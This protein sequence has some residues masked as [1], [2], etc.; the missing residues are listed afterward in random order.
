MLAC[1]PI[2]DGSN[3]PQPSLGGSDAPQPF[4]KEREDFL[5]AFSDEYKDDRSCLKTFTEFIESCAA[6]WDHSIYLASYTS[7]VQSSSTRKSRLLK[8]FTNDWYVIYCY[9]R[10]KGSS[11]IPACPWIADK[12]LQTL[13]SNKEHERLNCSFLYASFICACI[14]HLANFVNTNITPKEWCE[15]QLKE[16]MKESGGTNVSGIAFWKEIHKR[17]TK[18]QTKLLKKQGSDDGEVM[19]LLKSNIR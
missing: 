15:K 2:L 8:E 9:V 7:L 17:M 12:L 13:N 16:G 5:K 4:S 6:G 3:A 18:F 14:D 1:K 19:K 11:S 10:T